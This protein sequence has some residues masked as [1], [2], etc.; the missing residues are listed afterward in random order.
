MTLTVTR[1]TFRSFILD[2]Y[3][4]RLTSI[5]NALPLNYAYW[6]MS[7]LMSKTSIFC[8]KAEGEEE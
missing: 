7:L 8:A 6:L 4:L 3:F 5:T 1:L 2:P